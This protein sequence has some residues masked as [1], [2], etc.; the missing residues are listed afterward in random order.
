MKAFD[1]EK[2]L[3][4]WLEGAKYDLRVANAMFKSK[5]VSI[6]TFH[7]TSITGKASQGICCEI[8]KNTRSI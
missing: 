5:K 2:T 8:Y 6:S 4:Y 3:S 7:G 1:I